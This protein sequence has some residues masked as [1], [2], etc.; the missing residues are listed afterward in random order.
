MR[1]EE[2]DS[3][4]VDFDG[5]GIAQEDEVQWRFVPC[6]DSEGSNLASLGPGLS[7]DELKWEVLRLRSEGACAV[8]TSG[9]VKSALLPERSW[10]RF[11]TDESQGMWILVDGDQQGN[12]PDEPVNVATPSFQ[13]KSESPFLAQNDMPFLMKEKD[14][15]PSTTVPELSAL[16]S[17][18]YRGA[19]GGHSSVLS[20]R[21]DRS[22]KA[23]IME[24]KGKWEQQTVDKLH[25]AKNLTKQAVQSIMESD[26]VLGAAQKFTGHTNVVTTTI[27]KKIGRS[28][29]LCKA[30]EDRIESVE[31]TVRQAGECLFQLQ[32]AQR[33]KWGPLNVCERRLE[34]RDGRPIQELIRDHCQE[35]LESERTVLMEARAALADQTDRMKE[36]LLVLDRILGELREDLQH[37][38][39]GL[40]IDRSCLSPRKPSA[41]KERLVLPALQDVAHYGAPPSPKDTEPGTGQQHEEGR[42][43]GTQRL[44]SRAVRAEEDTIRLTNESDALIMST[45]RECSRASNQVQVELAKRSEEM[46]V[47]KKQLE[48]QMVETDE[49][50]AQTELSLG[51]TKQTL[52]SHDRPLRALDK[53]FAARQ[54]RTSREGIR[55][56]VHDEMEGHLETL[57]QNVRALTTKFQNSKDILE[58]LRISKQHLLQ[59]YRNKIQ[60]QKIDDACIKV[61]PRKSME[62]DRMDPRGGRC[63]EP[64]KRRQRNRDLMH[65]FEVG[66]SAHFL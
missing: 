59:D 45:R 24:M 1:D 38:R 27:K 64:P 31:D 32:R 36:Q 47:M 6:L 42:H 4:D 9:N 7:S 20:H 21:S 58:Q 30:L 28:Q 52:E 11:T 51:K 56:P 63:K 44:V 23:E 13:S 62:M 10:Q 39:H 15:M 61:T 26:A 53:Q 8:T 2:F 65:D 60:A 14:S 17:A 54:K 33:C 66:L 29:D 34:L 19:L 48:A 18:L 35:A 40:R 16:S 37:K 49:T 43:E 22:S 46:N 50:I 3:V 41:G 5:L 57:K 25:H 12:L 55:D